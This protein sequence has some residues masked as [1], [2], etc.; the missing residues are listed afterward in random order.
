MLDPNP[1]KHKSILTKVLK[2]SYDTKVRRIDSFEKDDALSGRRVSVFYNPKTKQAI[3]A[4]RGTYSLKDVYTDLKS[5]AGREDGKRFQHAQKIQKMAEDR[6]GAE[7]VHTVGHSLG[8]RIAEKVGQN[9]SEVITYNKL[10]TPS[11]ALEYVPFNQTDIRSENDPVSILAKL[12]RRRAESLITID[13]HQRPVVSHSL[14]T[15]D[16]TY[17]SEL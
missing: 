8:G 10:V 5:I 14:T 9:S 3:V 16:K 17:R 15:L 13:G 7:N 1:K 12:Q 11:S 6:F 2:A 4:H